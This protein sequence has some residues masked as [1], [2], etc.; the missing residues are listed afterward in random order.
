MRY[1][2][3][4]FI[5]SSEN[6]AKSHLQQSKA[7]VNYLKSHKK[8]NSVLD[9]GCGKL[10][11]SNVI[12]PLCEKVTFVDSK[13]QLSRK[14]LIRGYN[15]NIKNYISIHYPKCNAIA[16]E[17]LDNHISK[18]ELI[19]CI[20]VLS[21]IPCKNTIN[22]IIKHIKRLLYKNG[23]AVFINQYRNSYFKRYRTGIKHLYG[24]IYTANNKIS[25]YGLL[26]HNNII[27]LLFKNGFTI[28]KLWKIDGTN[29]IE[30]SIR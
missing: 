21:A 25:Y 29:F 16:F 18:Y 11:Y 7:V 5:I 13:I 12:V 24:Y 23:K 20:N 19:T 3:G 15:T 8:L 27:N 4:N 22:K 26:N 30:A 6:T 17:D 14:Q 9:F 1:K 28:Y 2:I 10:R